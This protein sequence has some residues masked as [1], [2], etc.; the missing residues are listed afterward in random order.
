[1]YKTLTVCKGSCYVVKKIKVFSSQA[2]QESPAVPA[3]DLNSFKDALCDYP[4]NY[5]APF[6]KNSILTTINDSFDSLYHYLPFT[7]LLRPPIF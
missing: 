4:L 6:T 5:A 2:S 3:F 7:F 1:M